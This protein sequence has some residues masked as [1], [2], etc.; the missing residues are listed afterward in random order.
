MIEDGMEKPL[1]PT[2]RKCSGK[3]IIRIS[4]YLHRRLAEQAEKER[5]SLN[6]YVECL[7]SERSPQEGISVG[8]KPVLISA[9]LYDRF[10][11]IVT[12]KG[13]GWRGRRESAYKAEDSAGDVAIIEFLDRLEHA[14]KQSIEETTAP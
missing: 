1:P 8:K 6:T 7:L 9:E 12:E 5:V 14:R 13:R 10:H 4:P 2:G 11:S 3:F